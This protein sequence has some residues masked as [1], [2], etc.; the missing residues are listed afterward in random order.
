MLAMAVGVIGVEFDSNEQ[1][2]AQTMDGIYR[3]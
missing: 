3:G 2:S 1:A